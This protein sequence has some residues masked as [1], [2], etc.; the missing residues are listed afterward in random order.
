MPNLLLHALAPE[1][2]PGVDL[3]ARFAQAM[4]QVEAKLIKLAANTPLLLLA[5]LII[6][7]S[8]W[9]GGFASRRM[10]LL[11]R[12]SKSNPYMDG[13]LRNIVKALIVLAG[14]LVALDLLGATSLVGAVLGSA[15]VVGLVLGFAFKDIAENYIAG[16]L[17]SLRQPFTPGN[18]VR[19]DSHEGKVVALTSRATVLMTMDGNHLQLP[20][21]LV[22]KSVLL[23][24]SRNPKRRF[25][26]ETTVDARASWHKAMDLGLAAMADVDGVIADPAPNAIIRALTNDGAALQF[27]GWVDQ[28]RNDLGKTRS[29]AMR[30]VRKALLD[31]GIRPPE[32]VQ[33]V[34]LV[35]TEHEQDHVYEVEAV[36]DTSVD[37]ALDAQVGH[38]RDREEAADGDL[39]KHAA[40]A[41]AAIQ[42]P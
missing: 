19:I 3:S 5:I 10:R 16:I 29:E 24:Y 18:H 11:T 39:L 40:D 2:L 26:F 1:R 36:R 38:A 13:L 4:G 20:N 14:V 41:P 9:L 35:R 12:L 31:A 15:G 27:T 28:T 8:V 17:L 6:L 32:T 30:R 25:E 42:S 22:F 37:R 7:F 23:N 33:R 34:V 21:S